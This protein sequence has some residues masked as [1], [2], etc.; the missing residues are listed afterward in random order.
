MTR[1]LKRIIK[2]T[3][4]YRYDME[5]VVCGKIRQ[6]SKHSYDNGYGKYCSQ[7]C[8]WKHLKTREDIKEKRF[9]FEK[10]R[11]PWNKNLTKETSEILKKQSE[12]RK[13]ENHPLFVNGPIINNGGYARIWD[14]GKRVLEHRYVMEKYLKRKLE[15][16]EE[17]HHI[18]GIK[19]DN[20]LKN[21]ELVI[22]EK[23]FGEIKCPY[24]QKIFKIK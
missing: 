8:Y 4:S 24:C 20:R 12:N 22:K 13:G 21:L 14:N 18:N 6:I 5:C 11:T 2:T 19:T 9:R 23:H 1:K 15:T 16:R 7:K 17:I 3:R 10:G